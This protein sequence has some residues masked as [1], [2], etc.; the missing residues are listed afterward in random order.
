MNNA[1]IIPHAINAPIFGI[2]M[3]LRKRPK[4]WTL[5]LKSDDI[6]HPFLCLRLGLRPEVYRECAAAEVAGPCSDAV[7]SGTESFNC[8]DSENLCDMCHVN[9]GG[10]A[11]NDVI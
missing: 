1:V 5:I 7:K 11:F 2:T 6:K 10:V 8:P 4:L 3:L 9:V